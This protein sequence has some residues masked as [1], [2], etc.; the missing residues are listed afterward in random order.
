MLNPLLK[1]KGFLI[2]YNPLKEKISRTVS[3]P[4]YYAGLSST[5]MVIEKGLTKK[6]YKLDR[7]YTIKMQVTIEAESYTWFLIE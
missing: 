3:V 5:A 2:V 1:E 7:N 4:L 6:S